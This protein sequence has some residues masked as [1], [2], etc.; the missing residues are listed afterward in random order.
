M[1]E[2]C[3]NNTAERDGQGDREREIEGGGGERGRE[4]GGGREEKEVNL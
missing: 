1:V 4:K 3:F 2:H